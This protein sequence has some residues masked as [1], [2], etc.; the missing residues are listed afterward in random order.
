MAVHQTSFGELAAMPLSELRKEIITQ[1]A[2]VSKMRLGIQLNKEKDS[3]KFRR[4]R[5]ALGR[6]LLA[7]ARVEGK[8][9]ELKSKPKSA[10]VSAPKS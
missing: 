7:F 4:E 3:A 10:T 5:R 8:A 1:R 6:M 2:L 9:K